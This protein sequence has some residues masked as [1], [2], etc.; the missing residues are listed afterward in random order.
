MMATV[1]SWQSV[2]VAVVATQEQLVFHFI[3]GDVVKFETNWISVEKS[4]CFLV[5]SLFRIEFAVGGGGRY[6]CMSASI[7]NGGC[8]MQKKCECVP[9]LYLIHSPSRGWDESRCERL[10]ACFE[11]VST[12]TR[13]VL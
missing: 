10:P 8:W 6:C 2:A 1:T 9:S 3:P 4:R 5:P 13:F 11:A 12:F 7:L